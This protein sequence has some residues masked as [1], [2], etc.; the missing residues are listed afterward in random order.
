MLIIIVIWNSRTGN[1]FT[2]S[3][4]RCRIIKLC[5]SSKKWWK[6]YHH[7]PNNFQSLISLCWCNVAIAR[8]SVSWDID[9]WLWTVFTLGDIDCFLRFVIGCD[10]RLCWY[11]SNLSDLISGKLVLGVCPNLK[12]DGVALFLGNTLSLNKMVAVPFVVKLLSW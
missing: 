10:V 5:R 11:P 1:K 12:V 4:K 7:S 8:F 3:D 6:I 2:Q 9:C